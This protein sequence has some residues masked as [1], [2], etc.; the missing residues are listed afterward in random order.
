MSAKRYKIRENEPRKRA[1]NLKAPTPVE[2]FEVFE[3]FSSLCFL[4][5]YDLRFENQFSNSAC[6]STTNIDI[7]QIKQYFSFKKQRK[8]LQVLTLQNRK[9]KPSLPA[10]STLETI[11]K[12]SE[13]IKKT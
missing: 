1:I 11:D 4:C 2:A 5:S 7:N 6:K 13:N 10:S 8:R 12:N 9:F 3:C